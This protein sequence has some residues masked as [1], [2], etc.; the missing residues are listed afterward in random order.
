MIKKEIGI[1]FVLGLAANVLGILVYILLFSDAGIK[2]SLAE[3]YQEQV[4]GRLIAAGAVLNFV[5]FFYY[6][7]KN[8]I[9]RA[10]GVVLASILAALLIGILQLFTP[11]SERENQPNSLPIA[12]KKLILSKDDFS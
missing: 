3:A 9:F 10:R 4:M 2:T 7:N 6:L 5:P 1:G 11:E 8:R 12:E